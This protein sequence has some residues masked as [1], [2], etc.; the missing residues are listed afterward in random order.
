MRYRYRILMNGNGLFAI[1][2]KACG[3]WAFTRLWR[4]LQAPGPKKDPDPERCRWYD[5]Q[6]YGFDDPALFTDV[7]L[8]VRALQTLK[9]RDLRELQAEE[10]H[11]VME[12]RL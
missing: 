11:P 4:S 9:D 12:D 2:R 7:R 5:P 8:A 1:E 3:F 6:T 10:W